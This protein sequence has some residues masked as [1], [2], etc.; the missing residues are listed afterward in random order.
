MIQ[1]CL[2]TKY[3][4]LLKT[5]V[6]NYTGAT[7]TAQKL[8]VEKNVA[9]LAALLHTIA[10]VTGNIGITE[11]YELAHPISSELKTVSQEANPT[12]TSSHLQKTIAVFTKLEKQLPIIEKFVRAN[13]KIAAATSEVSED[14][15]NERLADLAKA[16]EDNDMQAGEL[17]EEMIA[18]F[19]LNEEMKSKLIGIQKAL[20]EFEFDAALEILKK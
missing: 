1:K 8:V 7:A 13:A 5:F 6:D 16:I 14:E 10:G 15:L 4:K 20:D 11:I 3:F 2:K 12:L 19:T 18:K 17:C 9:E